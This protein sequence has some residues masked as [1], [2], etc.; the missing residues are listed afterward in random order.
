MGR[1]TDAAHGAIG[2]H[3]SYRPAKAAAFGIATGGVA[4]HS[5]FSE[6]VGQ[7]P[8]EYVGRVLELR[9]PR[10]RLRDSVGDLGEGRLLR[11]LY[12]REGIHRT[13]ARRRQ[14]TPT[15]VFYQRFYAPPL[16]PNT[17]G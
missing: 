7:A 9:V 2:A 3:Y 6:V 13:S 10:G 11:V 16:S 5:T 1:C 8:G 12:L 4:S 17:E 15:P 14:S